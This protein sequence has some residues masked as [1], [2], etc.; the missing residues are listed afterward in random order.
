MNPNEQGFYR[1]DGQPEQPAVDTQT[2]QSTPI[3]QV[4]GVETVESQSVSE[5]PVAEQSESPVDAGF[6]DDIQGDEISGDAVTWVAQEYI[7]REKGT[8]WFISFAAVI[9]VLL[10]L[11]VW[12]EAL[13][14]TVLIIVI[15]FVVILISKRPPRELTYSLTGEGLTI[16][17]TLQKFEDFKSF[18][19]VKDGEN[20]SIMLIPIQRF[21]PGISVYFPEESGEDIVDMLGAQLPMKELRLDAI[22]RIVRKLRL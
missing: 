17:E 15:T 12:T 5:V 22:D 8:G 1:P 11:S 2:A 20:F 13:T 4:S 14:F 18:G 7:H 21:K 3:N 19:V 10:G 9:V 16:D 6:Q